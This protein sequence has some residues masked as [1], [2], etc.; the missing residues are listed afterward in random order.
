MKTLACILLSFLMSAVTRADQA[1]RLQAG[2]VIQIT[3]DGV[4]EREKQ[5]INGPYCISATGTLRVPMIKSSIIAAGLSSKALSRKLEAEYKAAEIYLK[6]RIF[7]EKIAE[8]HT[9]PQ[10]KRFLTVGGTVAKPGPVLFKKG[11]TLWD[12]VKA[13]GR[14]NDKIFPSVTLSRAGK[15]RNYDL[16]QAKFRMILVFPNDT[17]LVHSPS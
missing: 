3:L 10:K 15:S 5:T 14:R 17:I 7:I 1:N 12:A 9:F 8:G 4:N 6:P 13:A 2:N 16:N 11:M